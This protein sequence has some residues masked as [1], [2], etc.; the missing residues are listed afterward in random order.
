MSEHHEWIWLEWFH[1]Q[2]RRDA[3]WCN[4]TGKWTHQNI[5][6]SC[7]EIRCVGY[8]CSLWVWAFEETAGISRSLIGQFIP[9]KGRKM[10][11]YIHYLKTHNHIMQMEKTAKL[12]YNQQ[13]SR[14]C[15][16]LCTRN[17]RQHQGSHIYTHT[18]CKYCRPQRHFCSDPMWSSAL[19]FFPPGAAR[20]AAER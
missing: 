20:Y 12:K 3:R 1:C 15:L 4:K 9:S 8:T 5:N 14:L 6:V 19:Q 10:T 13:Q 11:V 17:K 7:R 16:T 2:V 18:Q